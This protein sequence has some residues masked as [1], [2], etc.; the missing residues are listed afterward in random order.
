[1]VLYFIAIVPS[2]GL[3]ETIRRLKEDMREKYHTRHALKLPAHITLQAPFRMNEKTESDLFSDLEQ[4]A[5]GHD[6]FS[7]ELSG[8]GS[9]PPRV[10]FINIKNHEPIREL[11][12]H[13][14]EKMAERNFLRKKMS[15]LH[16]H[17]T[18]ATRDLDEKK[19]RKAWS[20]FQQRN[21]FGSF[22]ARNF[23]LFKHNG[24]TWDHFRDF[25]LKKR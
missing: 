13:L 21:F 15:K 24:V 7:V 8:F 18:L 22:T 11:H 19:F 25:D 17:I 16:P 10:I 1:M 2:S 6:P 9:F 3:K 12:R 4:V 23:T 14:Q 20:E 5:S